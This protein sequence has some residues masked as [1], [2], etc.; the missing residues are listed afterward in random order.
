M[1]S[2]KLIELA[3]E[4]PCKNNTISCCSLCIQPR[5][6]L[7]IN[8]EN[9]EKIEEKKKSFILI[10]NSYKLIQ[11]CRTCNPPNTAKL[12]FSGMRK[13]GHKNDR[14]FDK[15]KQSPKSQMHPL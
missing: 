13:P 1:T 6:D 12:L 14:L 9:V 7:F 3:S 2:C 11:K 5:S 10:C 15:I 8:L 4:N